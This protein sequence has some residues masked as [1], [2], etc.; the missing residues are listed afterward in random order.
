MKNDHDKFCHQHWSNDK[1][2]TL[3]KLKN[4]FYIT[5]W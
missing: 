1:I 3:N 4:Q 5:N 2:I